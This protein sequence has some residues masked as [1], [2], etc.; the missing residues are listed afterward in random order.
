MIEVQKLIRSALNKTCQLDPA[1]WVVKDMCDLL[2]PFLTSLFNKSLDT[3]C[4][5]T[6]F[7]QAVVRPL[8]KKNV[9]DD[10]ELKN[11]WPVSD[12]SFISK[13]L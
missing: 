3:G 12:L 8:V 6:E 13:L 5:L 4:F 9:L 10:N 7:K 1:P 11:F 2:S